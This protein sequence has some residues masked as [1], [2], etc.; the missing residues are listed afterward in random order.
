M[1]IAFRFIQDGQN[2]EPATLTR[3][4]QRKRLLYCFLSMMD[5]PP[6]DSLAKKSFLGWGEPYFH[7]FSV[8]AP[9]WP[10]NLPD[11]S[12]SAVAG[13]PQTHPWRLWAS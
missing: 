1:E 8:E 2:V 12:S 3:L 9:E 10:V 6:F 5:P 11:R 4:P 7:W 13:H